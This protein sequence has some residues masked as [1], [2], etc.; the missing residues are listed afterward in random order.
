[1]AAGCCACS[2]FGRSSWVGIS[3]HHPLLLHAT[4]TDR[5][6]RVQL[7]S[8]HSFP[9]ARGL[10]RTVVSHFVGHLSGRSRSHR[11]RNHRIHRRGRHGRRRRHKGRGHR[12]RWNVVRARGWRRKSERRR[13]LSLRHGRH[14]GPRA[15]SKRRLNRSRTQIR[16]RLLRNRWSGCFLHINAK[17]HRQRASETD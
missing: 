15:P 5:I 17:T 1:M 8:S 4:V 9:R 13:W 14:K 7:R 12:R 3:T 6:E 16:Q 11:G 10:H 2:A